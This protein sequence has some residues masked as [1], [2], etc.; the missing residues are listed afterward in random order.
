MKEG[1]NTVGYLKGLNGG[2][3][4]SR[5]ALLALI[6][7]TVHK[8]HNDNVVVVDV[9]VHKYPVMRDGREFVHGENAGVGEGLLELLNY[10]VGLIPG[11]GEGVDGDLAVLV[12]RAYGYLN[13][14]KMLA[15]FIDGGLYASSVMAQI[16]SVLIF[17]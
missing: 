15:V 14:D 6:G 16:P 4:A 11:G 8:A 1:R 12:G 3:E 2:N 7:L 13:G 5:K 9:F 10:L 17:L